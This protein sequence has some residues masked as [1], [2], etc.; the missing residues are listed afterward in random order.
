MS[1]LFGI[2]CLV[3]VIGVILFTKW[4]MYRICRDDDDDDNGDDHYY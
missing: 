4:C 1:P 3:A 2:I